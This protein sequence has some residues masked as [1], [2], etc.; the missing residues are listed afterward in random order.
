MPV[1][2]AVIAS[3]PAVTVPVHRRRLEADSVRRR[4]GGRDGSRW[5]I[6]ETSMPLACASSSPT[7]E[8]RNSAP[9]ATPLRLAHHDPRDVARARVLQQRRGG[10]RA[11]QRHGLRTERLGEPQ[12]L[13]A[14]V[15][16]GLSEPQQRR[17]L[18]GDDDPLGVER[19]GK[20][21]AE[22]H[23]LLAPGRPGR[24]R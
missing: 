20:A 3:G 4:G 18:D 21:L 7:V 22:P 13:D 24:R 9:Q 15:P 16:L 11:V 14:P 10:S 1:Q 6:T 2:A 12:H 5:A 8:R 17:G 19:V 23:Q